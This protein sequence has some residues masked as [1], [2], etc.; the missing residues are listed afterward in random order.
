MALRK[1]SKVST[2][3]CNE[4]LNLL[5]LILKVE[6]ITAELVSM[7]NKRRP[8]SRPVSK[9]DDSG[10]NYEN[11]NELHIPSNNGHSQPGNCFFL[12]LLPQ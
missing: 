9:D 3:V 8:K 12:L 6:V 7:S 11:I 4:L 5:F 10:F 2:H 1:Y